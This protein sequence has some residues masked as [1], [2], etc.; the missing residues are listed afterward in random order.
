V[1]DFFDED[2]IIYFNNQEELGEILEDLKVNGEA[3]FESKKAAVA[4]NFKLVEKYRI[5]EDWIYN[6]YRFLFK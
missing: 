2:G 1:S 3:I 5:P 6:N 4:N